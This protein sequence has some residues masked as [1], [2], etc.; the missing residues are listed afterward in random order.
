MSRTYRL[1][2]DLG[3]LHAFASQI[4]DLRGVIVAEANVHELHSHNVKTLCLY[5]NG[6]CT[7]TRRRW[8]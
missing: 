5:V 4:R 7:A 6:Q 2:D 1:S 3:E 8:A